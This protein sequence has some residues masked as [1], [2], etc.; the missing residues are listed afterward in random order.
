M[1][2]D[3]YARSLGCKLFCYVLHGVGL[4][5]LCLKLKLEASLES[6]YLRM[7]ST[8]R[9]IID[10]SVNASGILLGVLHYMP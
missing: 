9:E 5:H 4:G 3:A 7:F 8:T 1:N 6:H 2:G 10:I